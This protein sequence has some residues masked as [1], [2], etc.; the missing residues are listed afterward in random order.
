MSAKIC[1]LFKLSCD[2]CPSCN[3]NWGLV[4]DLYF[5]TLASE[6]SKRLNK[7]NERKIWES[8]LKTS[9]KAIYLVKFHN[10]T[11][12]QAFFQIFS[13]WA[14][15]HV[16]FNVFYYASPSFINFFTW[17]NMALSDLVSCTHFTIKKHIVTC[18]R[19][20]VFLD[21]LVYSE[22]PHSS[23]ILHTCAWRL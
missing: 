23:C 15:T 9:V 10:P 16:Y 21:L 19:S 3:I 11:K 5:Y 14:S 1:L 2:L 17:Y 8:C 12:K 22:E 4:W 6:T 18:F 7:S 13:T 20:C